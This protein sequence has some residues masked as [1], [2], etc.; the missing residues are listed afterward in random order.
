[1]HILQFLRPTP[2]QRFNPVASRNESVITGA[3][4]SGI[5][6]TQNQHRR[7]VT[8]ILDMPNVGSALGGVTS[9]M[10]SF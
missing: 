4:G 6:G 1:M 10:V 3:S 5:I 2:R 9:R 7:N 8:T